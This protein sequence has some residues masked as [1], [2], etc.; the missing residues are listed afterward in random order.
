[1][2]Q[3]IGCVGF[4]E[5][6]QVNLPKGTKI[7]PVFEM[8]LQWCL[9]RNPK[10]R[11]TFDQIVVVLSKVRQVYERAGGLTRTHQPETQSVFPSLD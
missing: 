6:H 11:I 2:P 9:R 1:V 7:P 5:T 4:D 8:L 3:I 10:E